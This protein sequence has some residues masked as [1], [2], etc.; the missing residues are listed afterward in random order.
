MQMLVV[1]ARSDVARLRELRSAHKL[2]LVT[3]PDATCFLGLGYMLEMQRDCA[4]H[5]LLVGCGD[6]AALAHEALRIGMKQVYAHVAPQMQHK[7]TAIA[8]QMQAMFTADYPADAV[9]I[10]SLSSL[11]HVQT[12]LQGAPHGINA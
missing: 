3:I 5:T 4:P 6:D 12:F 10:G 8:T 9:D 2:S 1:H 7:L 11:E